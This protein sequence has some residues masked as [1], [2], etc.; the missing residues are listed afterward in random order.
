[1]LENCVEKIG[2]L[3]IKLSVILCR[4]S[5]I[6][7]KNQLFTSKATTVI[8]AMAWTIAV[9]LPL[10]IS[11]FYINLPSEVFLKFATLKIITDAGIAVFFYYN[12]FRL[13]PQWIASKNTFKFIVIGILAYVLMFAFEITFFKLLIEKS[14]ILSYKGAYIR[15]F[16]PMP[17]VFG[18]LFYYVA[19]FVISTAMALNNHQKAQAERQKQI[20]FEKLSAEL[21]VLKLQVSPH[22]L[23]NT[24]NN[25]RS[26]VR[27]KSD[28]TEAVVIKL[29]NILRYMLYQSKADK[30]PLK[31]EIEH[32]SDYIELQKLRM[33]HPESV[34]FEIEGRIENVMI[35]P[36]LF[37]PFVEN[38]F[39]FGLHATTNAEIIFSIKIIGHTLL[40]ESQNQCFETEFEE[41]ENSGIGLEN[42]K[43]RLQLHYPNR[44]EMTI[45]EQGDIYSVK[46]KIELT[47]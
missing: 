23:F 44:H 47:V 18:L 38:A 1:M 31:K 11:P 33:S 19:A 40:F 45:I 17:K 26:L 29:S 34:K 4:K 20:E 13:T 14:L 35:E 39:K 8:H 9:V 22:F 27:K 25:I 5:L 32:L 28:K 41:E 42:V 6:M 46:I 24:L 12:Y 37:I 21:E 43:K 16:L 2:L 3:P 10:Y 7:M 15:G 30:V 36:L